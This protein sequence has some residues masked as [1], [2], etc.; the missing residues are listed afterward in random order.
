MKRIPSLIQPELPDK[1][2]AFNAPDS[3]TCRP[4]TDK[5]TQGFGLLAPGNGAL[6]QA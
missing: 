3:A 5:L 2:G 1:R 4:V 6:G